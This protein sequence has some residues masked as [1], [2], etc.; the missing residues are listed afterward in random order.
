MTRRVFIGLSFVTSAMLIMGSFQFFNTKKRFHNYIKNLWPGLDIDPGAIDQF[1]N[2]YYKYEG[3]N[4]YEGNTLTGQNKLFLILMFE[5][6][7][8]FHNIWQDLRKIF[9]EDLTSKVLLSTDF[10]QEGMDEGRTIKYILYYDPYINLCY[11][12]RP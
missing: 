1:I 9:R 11:N 3:Y 4:K 10:F 2:D 7:P 5:S 8:I 6:T 12:P